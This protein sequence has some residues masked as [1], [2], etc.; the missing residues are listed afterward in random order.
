MPCDLSRT[1]ALLDDV[2]RLFPHIAPP[3][4]RLRANVITDDAGVA[5]ANEILRQAHTLA[6]VSLSE[7]K[8]CVCVQ[9]YSLRVCALT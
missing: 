3:L 6:Y 9:C 2:L 1:V 8:V 5:L 7:T 4:H